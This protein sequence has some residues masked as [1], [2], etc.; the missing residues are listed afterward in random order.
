MAK[1]DAEKKV[2][3]WM[4]GRN[5]SDELS[6]CAVAIALVLVLI[7]FFLSSLIISI[8]ALV[9]IAYAWWRMLSKNL[10]DRENE[11]GVFIEFLGPLRPWVRNP[12]KAIGEARAYKHFKCPECGQRV[13][14][15][16]GKGKVRVRCPKCQHKF[17]ARA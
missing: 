13:R 11:N 12:A 8:V 16:R 7:N 5:G 10:E 4:Q 15:P 6:T 14:V 9:L 1:R 17:D 3:N 2:A